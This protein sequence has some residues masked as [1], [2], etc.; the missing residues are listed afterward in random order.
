MENNTPKYTE[1]A[2][3]EGAARTIKLRSGKIVSVFAGK[4]RDMSEASRLIKGDT[5]RLPA[6]LMARLVTV[7]GNKM[8]M[9]DYE[10]LPMTDYMAI[11]EVMSDVNLL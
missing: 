8:V 10:D 7:D 9:E 5:A 3:A 2:P 4:G 1:L 6:A 11:Q